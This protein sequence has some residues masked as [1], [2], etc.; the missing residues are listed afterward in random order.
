MSKSSE[1]W[2][3]EYES[4]ERLVQTISK[5]LNERSKF[6]SSSSNYRKVI[7]FIFL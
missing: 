6:P 3:T 7:K 2:L 5:N 4:I 1:K